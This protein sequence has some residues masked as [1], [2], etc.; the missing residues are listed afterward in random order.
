MNSP[1]KSLVWVLTDH[2]PG[3]SNQAIAIAEELGLAYKTKYIEYNLLAKLPN[4]ILQFFGLLFINKCTVESLITPPL[5]KIIISSGRRTALIALN[6]KR[7]LKNKLKIV[8]IMQPE[9]SKITSNVFDLI[10]IPQHDRLKN[11]STNL[12][13]TIGGI[14]NIYSKFLLEKE[15]LHINYPEIASQK[16]IAVIIGGSNHRYHFSS[17]AAHLFASILSRISKNHNLPL[18]IS[19]SSRTPLNVKEIIKNNLAKLHF[20]YDTLDKTPNPYAGMLAAAEYII[21]TADSISMCSEAASSGKPLYIFCPK[22]F[23]LKKHR[24]FIRN[25]VNKGIA[26][27]LDNDVERLESYDYQPLREI[28]KIVQRIKLILES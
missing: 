6:L 17:N 8:Q 5:P 2:R 16:F 11:S 23:Q 4:F 21:C 19:F 10:I 28:E 12:I 7:I 9:V 14:N 26:R 3:N 20:I 24:F 18:F 27:M 22:E 25:L 15:R 1:E 13:S